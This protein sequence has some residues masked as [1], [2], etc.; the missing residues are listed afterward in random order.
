MKSEACDGV[1]FWG[2]EIRGS[3][4]DCI[5]ENMIKFIHFKNVPNSFE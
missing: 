2:L 5:V 4:T 1:K 3:L